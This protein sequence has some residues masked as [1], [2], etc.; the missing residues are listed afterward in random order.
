MR[1]R[2][3]RVLRHLPQKAQEMG[4]DLPRPLVLGCKEYLLNQNPAPPQELF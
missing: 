1:Q 3:K 2:L 4:D